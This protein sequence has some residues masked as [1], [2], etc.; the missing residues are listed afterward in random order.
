M[1]RVEKA[2]PSPWSSSNR[3]QPWSPS[4]RRTQKNGHRITVLPAWSVQRSPASAS[5]WRPVRLIASSSSLAAVA[6]HPM[7]LPLPLE[8]WLQRSTQQLRLRE[9]PGSATWMCS[10]EVSADDDEVPLNWEDVAA[11]KIGRTKKAS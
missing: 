1:I 4:Q 10:L 7:E 11:P 9:L 8:H 2:R 3:Q 6:S 5:V